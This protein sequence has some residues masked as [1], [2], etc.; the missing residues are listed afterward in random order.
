VVMV[1]DG[2]IAAAGSA[3]A[4][5]V[6]AGVRMIHAEGRSLLPGLWEMHAHY[7]G[8]EFGPALLAAGVTTA[9]D[10]GGEFEFLTTVRS[11]ID[12][13]HALGPKL[14]LAGLI[15]SGGP[16]GFGYVDVKTPEEAVAAVDMYADAKFEQIKV[17]TQ[18]QPDVLKGISAEAHKRGMTVTGHV[19]AA[20]NAFE[21]IADGMD[22]IN[23]LQFVTRAMVP[24][25]HTG[26]VDLDSKRAQEM[27]AL[28]K[29]KHIVVDPTLG[30]G[31]MAGHPKS[32]DV[33]SF[34]PG[35][36]AAPYTLSSKFRALGVPAAD[37]AKFNERMK[38]NLE[39]VGALYRAGVT[40]VPGS[41]TGLLG[42]GLDRELELYV[43]AGM[44]PM[45]AIQSATIVAARVMKLDRETGSVEVGKR[46]DLVLVEGNPL[47]HISDIRRVVS[48]VAN[49]RMYDSKKLGRSVGFNR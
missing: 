12:R 47:E 9:R 16:L 10:C 11:K 46:A 29:E 2:R 19:P 13:D 38:T 36:K 23:H 42:Y 27:I 44:T 20:V 17:Y 40:I 5:K 48:V 22:Q 25:G 26:P 45:A 49:G 32:M 24:E 37:E 41:D 34:E 8:V 4:V 21:G 31:E 6:P 33:A 30:W 15:D 28:L 3:E 7:S 1:Q 18:I 35:I 43:Q 14:L 39:V